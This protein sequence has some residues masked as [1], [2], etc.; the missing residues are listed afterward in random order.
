MPALFLK[1]QR[2]AEANKAHVFKKSFMFM[3]I[4][5]MGM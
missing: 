4:L 3:G 5:P 2:L 1:M